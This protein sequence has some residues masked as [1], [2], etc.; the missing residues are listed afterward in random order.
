MVDTVVV[1]QVKIKETQE[2]TDKKV[3]KVVRQ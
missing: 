2:V 3:M 1:I